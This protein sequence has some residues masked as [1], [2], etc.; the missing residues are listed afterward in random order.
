VNNF[1]YVWLIFPKGMSRKDKME[2]KYAKLT[3]LTV[4]VDA[5]CAGVSIAVSVVTGAL[6]V[7]S[8]KPVLSVVLLSLL[9]AFLG[10]LFCEI[11]VFL[12]CKP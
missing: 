9:V 2:W 10:S 5:S 6:N 3:N 8:S 7:S 4:C 11:S 1:S 12:C